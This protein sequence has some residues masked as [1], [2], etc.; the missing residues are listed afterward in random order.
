MGIVGNSLAENKRR[1]VSP[2]VVKKQVKP[3]P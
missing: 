1:D 2:N 3:N